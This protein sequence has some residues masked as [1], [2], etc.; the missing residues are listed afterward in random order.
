MHTL[1]KCHSR[2]LVNRHGNTVCR[3]GYKKCYTKPL[4]NS[5]ASV[6]SRCGHKK[7]HSKTPLSSAE[8]SVPRAPSSLASAPA[9]AFF[10]Y[11]C[12]LT[13][14]SAEKR[15]KTPDRH[16]LACAQTSL[17]SFVPR[18]VEPSARRLLQVPKGNT[19]RRFGWGC[20]ARF[21]KPL[22]YFRPKCVI[23]STLFHTRPKI[24]K[25]YSLFQTK[26]AQKPYPLAPHIP[27]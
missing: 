26:K 6:I 14:T 10:F 7:Y 25:I 17:I 24:G 15:A 20:A 19:S 1:K 22:P 27:I 23:F 21:W 11:W 2:P 3:H 9:P 8:A 16:R 4:V 13:G 12:L 5:D 18:R